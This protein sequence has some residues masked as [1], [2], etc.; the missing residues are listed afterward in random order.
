MSD[1]KVI[2]SDADN[3]LWDTNAVFAAAQISLLAA[4]ESATGM[5]ALSDDRLAF[6]RLYDQMLASIHHLHF[7]YPTLL[8]VFAL[9]AGLKGNSAEDAARLAIHGQAHGRVLS[10]ST[11]TRISSE[12]EKNLGAIP[13]LLPGVLAGLECAKS[14]NI[15]VFVLTEGRVE[16]QREISANFGLSHM[17]SGIFEVTKNPAQFVRLRERFSPGQVILIG[18]Q[19]DRD[20]APAVEAGCQAVLIPSKFRPNWYS[21]ESASKA[22]FIATSFDEAVSW[23]LRL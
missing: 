14:D 10:L 12:Y 13:T 3:T 19:P 4:I 7:R 22:S 6:V 11:A 16:R 1:K 2:L 21:E 5:R 15:N 23:V 17:F 8:L 9:S 20:I 18:D